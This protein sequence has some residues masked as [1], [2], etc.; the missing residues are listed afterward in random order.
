MTRIM[1]AAQT[2]DLEAAR[3]LV[4]PSPA[5]ELRYQLCPGHRLEGST[6]LRLLAARFP[7]PGPPWL[8]AFYVALVD[9][10]RP[11]CSKPSPHPFSC[12]FSAG[13]G[14]RI[15]VRGRAGRLVQL[16]RQSL[17]GHVCNLVIMRVPLGS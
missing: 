12:E 15:F 16:P 5:A 8:E 6:V 17:A 10:V 9:K 1:L 2:K 7:S 14:S 13:L 11:A 3:A 4:A